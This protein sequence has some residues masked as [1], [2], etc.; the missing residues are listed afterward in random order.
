MA[1]LVWMSF[2][3]LLAHSS[4][5][6]AQTVP[7]K[8]VYELS[9][10]GIPV[11]TATQEITE[12]GNVRRILST[13]RSNDWLSVF[14]PVDDLIESILVKGGAP[15]PGL[16][17]Y[18]RMQIREGR[19][20]R[21]REITFDQAKG[22]AVYHDRR[23]NELREIP[24]PSPTFDIYGSFY[25]TRHL[26]LEVGKSYVVAVLDGKDVERVEVRVLRR[27]KLKTV[28]GELNTIVIRP[29]VKSE[30]VFEGKGSVHI[31]LTDDKRRIP[32]RAQTKVTV[33][34]VTANLIGGSYGP[35][36]H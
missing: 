10:T 29:M 36:S 34:S 5:T 9:W 8:L 14:F 18:Y 31:W 30:G 3:A 11:G 20:N 6:F 7:E 13:A 25:F 27:E 19:H 26:P 23:S 35:A 24:I 1:V 22:V 28:L 16:T 33:G 2:E 21:D 4:G 17:R 12:R 15:F 32:V